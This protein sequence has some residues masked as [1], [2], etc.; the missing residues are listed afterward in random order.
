[1]DRVA[2][3]AVLAADVVVRTMVVVAQT[4]VVVVRTTVVVVRTT[5]VVARTTVV[6]ARTTVVVARTTVVT[7]HSSDDH[8]TGN[9]LGWLGVGVLLSGGLFHVLHVLVSLGLGKRLY[10]SGM[11]VQKLVSNVPTIL[12]DN[13][14]WLQK[15]YFNFAFRLSKIKDFIRSTE[16][17]FYK[18]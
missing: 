4:T 5:V 11:V 15:E 9:G 8:C 12:I 6:V 16:L 18:I 10:S 14:H 2:A 1:M 3:I 13:I 17:S 7:C